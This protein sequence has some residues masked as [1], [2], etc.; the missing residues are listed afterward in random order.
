[1][2]EAKQ[3][4]DS[5]DLTLMFMYCE[6]KIKQLEENE[7]NA[8]TTMVLL[9]EENINYKQALNEIREYCNNPFNWRYTDHYIE[10]ETV[11]QI[12]DKVLGEDKE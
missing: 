3:Y 11:L 8:T 12:I 6:D 5:E 9:N 4:E 7:K 10:K 1:M 2:K